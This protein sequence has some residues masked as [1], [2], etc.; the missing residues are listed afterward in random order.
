MVE[1]LSFKSHSFT[2]KTSLTFLALNCVLGLVIFFT[3]RLVEFPSIE[4][5]SYL[6][7]ALFSGT[8]AWF[9]YQKRTRALWYAALL[10]G[11][12]IVEVSGDDWSIG[13]TAPVKVLASW[14]SMG[15]TF[16]INALSIIALGL[17]IFALNKI[18]K[19]RLV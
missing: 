9:I 8:L 7:V 1:N 13:L 17:V 5:I 11:A 2:T 6:L 4:S 12:Q 16:G 14:Q 10:F 19:E 18:R 15:L 3:V